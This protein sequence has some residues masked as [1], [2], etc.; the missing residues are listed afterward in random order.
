[1]ATCNTTK[2]FLALAICFLAMTASVAGSACVARIH[3]FDCDARNTGLIFDKHSQLTERPTSNPGSL[4]LRKRCPVS[5]SLQ[6][7]KGYSSAG[8]LGGLDEFLGNLV[9]DIFPKSRLLS[10]HFQNRFVAPLAYFSGCTSSLL[11]NGFPPLECGYSLGLNCFGLMDVAVGIDDYID[12]SHIDAYEVAGLYRRGIGNVY[13]HHQEPFAI[14]EQKAAL[15]FA[16]RKAVFLVLT[17]DERD[18]DATMER[19]NAHA[20]YAFES[21]ILAHRI[22]HSGVF[23]ELWNDILA[24]SVIRFANPSEASAGHIGRQAEFISQFIVGRFMKVERPRNFLRESKTCKPRR[25]LIEPFDSILQPLF[26]VGLR[27]QFGLQSEFHKGIVWRI[28]PY[29]NADDK[30]RGP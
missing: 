17:H 27:E 20:I 15:S 25:G 12:D 11:A 7:F 26:G 5:D 14:F 22:G 10:P 19:R 21:D 3:D 6:V 28:A 8:V 2:S 13:C 23:L 9:I 29:V 18:N 4:T 24:A 1:M 16:K 30:K